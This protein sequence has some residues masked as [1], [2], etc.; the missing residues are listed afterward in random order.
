[1]G[2]IFNDFHKEKD[3]YPNICALYVKEE[4]RNKKIATNLINKVCSDLIS[5]KINKAYLITSR[6]NF[7][8]KLGFKYL[9]N[10]HE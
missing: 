1:M 10:I 6:T 8:E 4:Y 5:Y 3:L 2:V 9:K 7:Y